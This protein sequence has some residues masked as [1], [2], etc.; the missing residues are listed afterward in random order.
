[1]EKECSFIWETEI[2]K[3]W[4][5]A[6]D[7]VKFSIL[8]HYMKEY[9]VDETYDN[10]ILLTLA[11]HGFLKIEYDRQVDESVLRH[12]K[13]ENIWLKK[14]GD[15]VAK[16]MF[17]HSI[18]VVHSVP[19]NHSLYPLVECVKSHFVNN[20]SHSYKLYAS[21]FEADFKLTYLLS[22]IGEKKLRENI[23]RIFL[24][25][26]Q[27][28]SDTAFTYRL[29]PD[30]ISRIIPKEKKDES[31]LSPEIVYS[32]STN[33]DRN[34]GEWESFALKFLDIKQGSVLDFYAG[35]GTLAMQMNLD[36]VAYT[37]NMSQQKEHDLMNM[38]FFT[39]ADFSDLLAKHQIQLFNDG[40]KGLEMR[41]LMGA[42]FD[43]I[44]ANCFNDKLYGENRNSLGELDLL[45]A[46]YILLSSKG[47]AL[48]AWHNRDFRT[49]R[50]YMCLIDSIILLSIDISV[51]LLNKNKEPDDVI[52]VYDCTNWKIFTAEQLLGSIHKQDTLHLLTQEDIKKMGGYFN[53]DVF[54]RKQYKV[55]VPIGLKLVRLSDVAERVVLHEKA[56]ENTKI[57]L[58]AEEYKPLS[59]YISAARSRSRNKFDDISSVDIFLIDRKL[60]LI[61]SGYT[62]KTFR[63]LIFD[64]RDGEVGVSF[65][66]CLVV[67]E[68]KV[69]I[70]YLVYEM[71]QEYFLRQLFPHE[72][73]NVY[74]IK[75]EDILSCQIL[76]PDVESSVERQKQD[77]EDL[78]QKEIAKIAQRYGFDLGK[79]VQYKASD[80]LKG[81]TLRNGKYTILKGIGHGGF[82]KVYEARN[83]ETGEIVAI[84]EFFYHS[85]QVR[86]PETNNVRT[87]FADIGYVDNAK[88]KF[89]RER[90]KIKECAHDHI[91]QVY[92]EF[93]ENNTCY[94]VMEYIDGKT[95]KDYCNLEERKALAIIRQVA[96]ALK[97][98]HE[99]GYNH[100]D[101]KPQN[102]LL[103]SN[104][105]A[106]LIDFSGAHHYEDDEKEGLSITGN[107]IPMEIKTPGYTPDCAYKAKGFHA[108]RDIYSLGATL[109]YM[110]T[111]NS[112]A[113]IDK[114]MK[115]DK[116][117]TGS[118]N[119]ICCAMEEDPRIWLKSMDE[120]LA[121]LP[122]D[123]E[124]G[125][126]DVPE[127]TRKWRI[128]P[129]PIVEL[130][131]DE[132][133]VFGSNKA[134]HHSGGAAKQA[135]KWGAKWYVAS[136]PMG[137]TYGIPTV[138]VHGLDEIE[139][140]VQQFITYVERNDHITFYVTAIGCG[141]AGFTP[142]Q[143]APLFKDCVDMSNV[144]LPES[145][146]QVFM[147]KGFIRGEDYKVALRGNHTK[148][149]GMQEGGDKKHDETTKKEQ[150]RKEKRR[151]FR[152]L[153]KAF[154]ND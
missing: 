53:I 107:S 54:K 41:G 96:E 32:A 77:I 154:K 85:R 90:D 120:F 141:S 9:N 16:D 75:A 126:I 43:Y 66:I 71:N 84:K 151:S 65:Y 6:S 21:K 67:D 31:H 20:Y 19:E 97:S 4:E 52:R 110:L 5:A 95:L 73:D 51:V 82:G 23:R 131:N 106:T 132:V 17:G 103:D 140:H 69:S 35:I 149:R 104:G 33:M 15:R 34:Y 144:Y 58:Y 48:V 152:E 26:Y 135:L 50:S 139:R 93:D 18:S 153:V 39:D 24:D 123:E 122:G 63:P 45:N 100:S 46:I 22:L 108:G 56:L 42:S 134:G 49:C 109:Y 80:L 127:P 27:P 147:T 64:P 146:W 94:Y 10:Y 11:A 1:M 76:V 119:A 129:R 8:I 114:Q 29:R 105:V 47:K 7:E 143:I 60:L 128:T 57:L 30:G 68:E 44:V 118:W 145:F 130:K 142:E 61:G 89:R 14:E 112:P 88:E 99:K 36:N 102:I 25:T 138:G 150:E 37:A 121:L 101:V 3:T 13:K 117:S 124:I 86:D 79:F 40:L 111:G 78:R 87:N 116:I 38:L 115:P 59:P 74:S 92:E 62:K 28:K 113:T 91:V 70:D 136:G 133:F 137:Q 55:D 148:Q 125:D 12:M 98:M 81:M 72:G 83:E 2:F